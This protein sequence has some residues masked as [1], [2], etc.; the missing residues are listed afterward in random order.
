MVCN[1]QIESNSHITDVNL[2]S[3][4]TCQQFEDV[5]SSD[6]GTHPGP[7]VGIP[8][9]ILTG[10]DS[11]CHARR[12]IERTSSR[13]YVARSLDQN[14]VLKRTITGVHGSRNRFGQRDSRTVSQSDS[15]AKRYGDQPF[16]RIEK[17]LVR[18]QFHARR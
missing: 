6:A 16:Q 5:F 12:R 11:I 9:G 3:L 8:Q 10:R 7:I 13:H 15:R 2:P 4:G 14:T 1:G 18:R 17:T